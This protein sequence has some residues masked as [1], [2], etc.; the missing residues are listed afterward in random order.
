MTSL[1]LKLRI[2]DQKIKKEV[3]KLNTPKIA[4]EVAPSVPSKR[5]CF[6]NVERCHWFSA[7]WLLSNKIALGIRDAAAEKK[8]VPGTVRLDLMTKGST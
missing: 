2:I 7:Y 4:L 5:S 3:W 1:W 6:R 8:E